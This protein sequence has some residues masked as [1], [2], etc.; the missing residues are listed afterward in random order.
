MKNFKH[1]I[2]TTLAQLLLLFQKTIFLC[3]EVHLLFHTEL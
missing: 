2:Q 1:P 3:N